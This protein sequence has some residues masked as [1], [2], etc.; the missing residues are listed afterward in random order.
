MIA[1]DKFAAT[2]A[3]S[4]E[5][6][7]ALLHDQYAAAA[8]EPSPDLPAELA[9]LDF[10]VALNARERLRSLVEDPELAKFAPSGNVALSVACFFI[11]ATVAAA[12]HRGDEARWD[13]TLIDLVSRV[14]MPG[15]LSRVL[16]D[17]H[18]GRAPWASED[19]QA[20]AAAILMTFNAAQREDIALTCAAVYLEAL[21]DAAVQH[22]L[23]VRQVVLGLGQVKMLT[24]IDEDLDLL[25]AK[26]SDGGPRF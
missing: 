9:A 23:D 25:R 26:G 6:L 20:N 16:L 4:L 22:N 1:T 14:D 18:R 5:V 13:A 24:E 2:Q 3:L 10:S 21:R 19:A 7:T 11:S 17:L 8:P 15:E 12:A